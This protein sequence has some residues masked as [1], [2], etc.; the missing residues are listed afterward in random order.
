MRLGRG[1]YAQV[2]PFNLDLGGARKQLG[3]RVYFF[4]SKKECEGRAND[5][6]T[7]PGDFLP[8]TPPGRG[9]PALVQLFLD[10]SLEGES[11]GGERSMTFTPRILKNF[12]VPAVCP[13]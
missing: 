3:L 2:C 6:S 13:S 1:V 4:L 12:L 5:G 8:S 7:H 11:G 9:L 10:R